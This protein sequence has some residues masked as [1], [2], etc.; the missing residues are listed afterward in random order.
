MSRPLTHR[1]RLADLRARYVDRRTVARQLL[2]EA[3]ALADSTVIELQAGHEAQ[4]AE[5]ERQHQLQTAQFEARLGRVE[6]RAQQAEER[7]RVLEAARTNLR[8]SRETIAEGVLVK[9]KSPR[10]YNNRTDEEEPFGRPWTLGELEAVCYRFRLGGGTDDTEVRNKRDH[11]E[12]TI[13]YPEMA[14]S[15]PEKPAPV[16]TE[17][18]RARWWKRRAA[19]ATAC[20]LLGIALQYVV[21]LLG[22]GS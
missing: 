16:A 15:A 12:A 17:Q 7:V 2:D 10:T 8:E 5:V 9:I 4:V 21:S 22:A 11:T 19:V 18:P 6:Y 20:V 14:L 1:Q 13:P 3:L